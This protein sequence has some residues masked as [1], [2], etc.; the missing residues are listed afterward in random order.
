MPASPSSNS[1]DRPIPSGLQVLLERKIKSRRRELDQHVVYRRTEIFDKLTARIQEYLPDSSQRPGRFSIFRATY[2]EMVA[3]AVEVSQR[4]PKM[5]WQSILETAESTALA[6]ENVGELQQLLEAFTWKEASD[7]FTLELVEPEPVQLAMERVLGR[8]GLRGCKVEAHFEHRRN[9]EV[10]GAKVAVQEA[11]R[12]SKEHATLAIESF[13]F[14]DSKRIDPSSQESQPATGAKSGDYC[15]PNPPK[16]KDEWYYVIR[17]AA[18]EFYE[19]SGKWPT[20]EKLWVQLRSS[21]P[22]NY[23]ITSGK[24]RGESAILMDELTLCKRAFKQRWARYIQRNPTQ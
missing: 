10:A 18:R 17:D 19:L 6:Q 20:A 15:I 5:V 13:R 3:L 23:G 24:D 11:A 1:A 7:A 8:Y 2:R 21:P 22:S 12:G 14:S 9:L 16:R 4:W